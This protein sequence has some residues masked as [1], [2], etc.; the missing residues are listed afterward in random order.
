M[1]CL[2]SKKR[3]ALVTTRRVMFVASWYKWC[4]LQV[5]VAKNVDEAFVLALALAL[6]D[7]QS[8]AH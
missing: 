6:V 7:M 1:T 5:N 3:H 2:L 4:C 8:A